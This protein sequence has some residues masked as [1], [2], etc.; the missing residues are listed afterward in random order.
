MNKFLAFLVGCL[1][2]VGLLAVQSVYYSR[3]EDGDDNGVWADGN[4]CV[5]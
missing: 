2:G 4:V 1:A 3:E 5:A